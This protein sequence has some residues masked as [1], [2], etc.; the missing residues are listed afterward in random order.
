MPYEIF[1]VGG[2]VRDDLLNIPVTDRDWVVVGATPEDLLDQGYRPVGRDFPVFL[3]PQTQEDYALARQE[4]KQG[5]GHRGFAVFSDP[6]VTL[7][8][9]L[10]RRDLTI[11]AMARS[12][13]GELVDPYGGSADLDCRVLRH[14]SDAFREDPLR[15]FRV[16]RFAAQLPGFSVHGETLALMQSM[17]QSGEL[18]SLS[19]ERVWQETHK[20]LAAHDTHRYFEVLQ[21]V[22][23]LSFWFAELEGSRMPPL[24]SSDLQAY[25]TLPLD[26]EGFTS[27]GA[28][29]K[30][31]TL[32]QQTA[33]DVVRWQSLI[34]RFPQ[35]E[36]AAFCDM[37]SQTKALH[38]IERL[39]RLL[40]ITGLA[41]QH[42]LQLLEWL[43]ALRELK[44]DAQSY[45]GA[46]YGVELRRLQEQWVT[47]QLRALAQPER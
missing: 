35:V 14:V 42:R 39:E 2:A 37:L 46:A 24:A 5:K 13:Q 12:A 8:Q 33:Q 29:L 43:A 1:L 28:R 4:R 9:D 17:A 38:A 15:V 34:S 10:A 44:P 41:H 7:E 21:Q 40:D 23:A 6:S 18:S 22:G 47:D 20:A 26:S 45:Q 31:P 3:H 11:N 32:F 19:A 30:V 16:A 27:L 36:A 25:A